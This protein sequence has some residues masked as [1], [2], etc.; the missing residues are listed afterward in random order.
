MMGLGFDW[1]ELEASET[2]AVLQL[3]DMASVYR[4][5]VSCGKMPNEQQ[6]LLLQKWT[7]AMDELHQAA[8]LDVEQSLGS[9]HV[10]LSKVARIVERT[11]SED[12]ETTGTT[13]FP[14]RLLLAETKKKWHALQF[15]NLVLAKRRQATK[16]LSQSVRKCEV[17]LSK[18]ATES[19]HAAAHAERVTKQRVESM[20]NDLV[21]H[22]VK[23][24][25]ELRAQLACVAEQ[26]EAA[27]RGTSTDLSS[28]RW[29]TAM[30]FSAKLPLAGLRPDAVSD[31]KLSDL[32][33]SLSKEDCP[34]DDELADEVHSCSDE[35]KK[36]EE[37][38]RA[39]SSE[40]TAAGSTF[41]ADADAEIISKDCPAALPEV[42]KGRGAT[43]QDASL[44]ALLGEMSPGRR[45]Q[46]W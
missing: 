6:T 23:T 3:S 40:S 21:T 45:K 36:E 10:P 33:V 42:S 37:F 19:L 14:S 38:R 39:T 34:E 32:V 46:E 5:T 35:E 17:S 43:A 29:K 24:Q 44:Y 15:E 11:L 22:L 9:L 8:G 7:A 13:K 25:H 41:G 31:Q 18:E 12:A 2:Q 16:L 4:A 27:I 26:H 30:T 28:S 20:A 1:D